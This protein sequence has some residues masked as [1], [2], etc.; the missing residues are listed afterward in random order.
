MCSGGELGDKNKI[1]S[2]VLKS[3]FQNKFKF[4]TK[5]DLNNNNIF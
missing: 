2:M 5:I 4:L 3:K 1:K